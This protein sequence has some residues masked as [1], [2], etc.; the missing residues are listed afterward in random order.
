MLNE[1]TGEYE[2][3]LTDGTTTTN[4]V[5]A[6]LLE[7]ITRTIVVDNNNDNFEV[8]DK[9]MKIYRNR[10]KFSPA[11]DPYITFKLT[12]KKYTLEETREFL[13]KL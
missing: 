11:K 2:Y 4:F 1:S 5:N 12:N 13:N 8:V 9:L 3:V 6:N 10:I 7:S